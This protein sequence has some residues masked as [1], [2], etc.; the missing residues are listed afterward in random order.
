[1]SDDSTISPLAGIRVINLGGAWAGRVATMLLADQGADVID[2]ARPGRA[3]HPADGLMDRG[4]RVVEIDLK[5]PGGLAMA[6][7]MAVGADIII[8]NMRPGSAERL[9]LGYD[10]LIEAGATSVY[11]ALHGFAEGDA[12]RDVHAWEGVIDASV[13]VFTDISALGQLLGGDPIYTAIPMASA[14]GGVH[15][16]LAASLGLYHLC[17]T[18]HG[19]RIEVPLA[20]AVMSAMALLAA[21]FEGQPARYN[22]PTV[23]NPMVDVAFPILRDLRAQLTDDHLTAVVD[24]LGQFQP[25]TFGSFECADGRLLFVTATDHVYQTRAFLQSV[26][27][28]DQLVAEGMV[29]ASPYVGDDGGNNIFSAGSMA[30]AWRRRIH[31]LV[32]ARLI[33]R[34]ARDWELDLRDANVPVTVVQTTAE[35]LSRQPLQAGGVTIGLTDPLDGPTSQP[36]R[37]VTIEGA[38]SE[39]PPVTPR[40]QVS[41]DVAW[42]DERV[43][44]TAGAGRPNGG[45]M[46]DG[47]RVLDLS[48]IIAGPAAGRTLAEFGADVIRLDSPTPLAGP[49]LTMWFG[50]DVNQGK[51]AIVLDL[52]TPDGREAFNRLVKGADVVLHNFLDRSAVS[53]GIDHASLAAINPNIIS[54]QVSAWGGQNGGPYKDDPAFDPVLQ[55][56]TGIMTRYGSE[57]APLMHATASCV[58]YIT[59]FSAALGIAQALVA[60]EM[61]RGGAAVRT[62]L[63]MGAQLVQFPLMVDHENAALG[64]EPS[65]QRALGDG[66][67][68][69][70]YRTRDGWAFIGC[71][72]ASTPDLAAALGAP[73]VAEASLVAAIERLSFDEVSAKIADVQGACA[74]RVKTL[75]SIRRV[76][77]TEDD[78]ASTVAVDGGSLKMTRAASHPC[79]YPTTLPLPTWIRPSKTPVKRLSPAPWPGEHTVEVL[80]EVGCDDDTVARM[81]HTAAARESWPVMKAYLP[82]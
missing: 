81:L 1:M 56:A 68:Q 22:L 38:G 24:Y 6:K 5:S 67:N 26:G 78:Q 65:G 31:E 54:C 69:R 58:D 14:Y 40:A 32:A 79:G 10:A 75:E 60:R 12:N 51:R 20:D 13:G 3:S 4:K 30:P 37:F 59:G 11:V 16:A 29:A 25:P 74:V 45:G 77:T 33:T 41:G 28:Y 52:K 57:E 47:V 18:G 71:P 17:R 53:L 62:S 43:A 76:S 66:A 15:G 7:G 39:S 64:S 55:A 73:D 63:A 21:K 19:Q 36:G 27:V 70:L 46:L 49:R 61:G 9:G 80:R 50:L 42:R 48:N 2:I 35:W 44:V 23:D 82:T 72:E 34:A 8:D